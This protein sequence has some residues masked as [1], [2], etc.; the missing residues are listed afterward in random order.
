MTTFNITTEV[1]Y[2]SLTPKQ[3]NDS[4]NVNGGRLV[5]DCDTR[6]GPNTTAATG[7][8]GGFTASASLGGDL[9]V[10]GT[11]VRLIPFDS[12]SSTIPA[13]GT[14]ITCSTGTAE[15][16]CVM[17]EKHGG[18]MYASG[19]AMPTTGW[20]KVRNV[21]GTFGAEA[22]SGISCSATGAD[23]VGW[24][25]LAGAQD[26][27][28]THSR[29]GT[30]VFNG[31][32]YY[33]GVTNGTAGQTIQL[34]Y[35]VAEGIMAYPGVEIE[36]APGSDVYLFHPNAA[37]KFTSTHCSTDS[38]SSFVGISNAGVLI[39]GKGFDNSLCGYLPVAGCKVR[40]PNIITQCAGITGLA[41]NVTPNE[42]LS[43]R[44]KSNYMSSGN[45]WLKNVTG[46]WYWSI[47]QAYNCYI[48][49]LHGCDQILI[50]E[51]ATKLDI[52]EVHSG[53]SNYAGAPLAVNPLLFQQ[54]YNGGT[55]GSISGLRAESISNSGY[56]GMFVNLYDK[57]TFKEIRIGH[58]GIPTAVN[59]SLYINTCTNIVIDTLRTFTKRFVASSCSNVIVKE[60]YYADACV[61]TTQVTQPCSGV[62]LFGST[63][64]ATI[65]NF[66]NWPGV[67]N[68]H[69]Y[70]GLIY[71]STAINVK[72]RFCGT[73]QNPYNTGTIN[74]SGH[75]Y[76]DGGNNTNIKIQRNWVT[77]VRTSLHSGTN[78][79]KNLT[80]VNNYSIDPSK[81]IGPQQLDSQ[82]YANRHN[83]GGN[84]TSY[85][86]VYGNAMWDAFT[87]DTTT[88]ASLILSEKTSYNQD[89]YAINSGNPVFTS[90]GALVMKNLGDSATWTWPW[91][92]KGWT[93][94]STHLSQGQNTLNF[95]YEY[96]LD[97]GSGFSGIFK[98][99]NSTNLQSETG[100]DPV[101]GFRLRI[102]ISCAIAAIT[103]RL[104]GFRIDGTTTLAL[105]NEAL[106]PLDQAILNISGVAS[107]STVA[108]FKASY[109]L[110]SAPEAVATD[111][112]ASTVTLKYDYDESQ[113]HYI[114]KIRKPGYD[115]IE[116][117]YVNMLKTDIPV[118]QQENKDGF[119]VVVYGRGDNSTKAFVTISAP[120]S[121]IDVGNYRCKAEDVYDLVV[122]WQASV[123]G[124]RYNEVLRFDG[125][126]IIMMN[127]WRFRRALS[128]YTS[129]GLDALPVVDGQANASPDD[130]TNG[131]VDFKARS[132]RTYYINQQP[133]YTLNDFA[134]AVWDYSQ[135]NGLSAQTN[136]LKTKIAAETAVAIAASI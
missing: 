126:D 30:S 87:G 63:T 73:P 4:F 109:V 37:N 83:A 93:G 110:G 36:T 49:D 42:N 5:I 50:Q 89:A 39:I 56:A 64:D 116:L 123:T 69:P 82:V 8:L 28:H 113:S 9:I 33:V 115:P 3:G 119:S 128:V 127:G 10:N 59:G 19:A 32:K 48:R 61:G 130:E 107:G 16:L 79:T 40:I 26:K 20:L 114:V 55:V 38:R 88:R 90:Q 135:I 6:Y 77:G 2:T 78:T 27:S 117:T 91:V 1:N 68:I 86:A 106:Y 131:S 58:T 53:L 12:A 96:D 94:L 13:Y 43:K 57:W 71:C 105:Q 76:V 122:D 132:V 104:D 70:L 24:M 25:F 136:L 80:F 133:V 18:I 124:I 97:K 52:D 22:L 112:T 35:V 85:I 65:L 51:I 54:C 31:L 62:E 98:V 29:L 103:N 66:K 100:F 101:N 15:L 44:Y 129:A 21:V 14:T 99:V 75:I 81:T 34:P 74:Q 134:A 7:V 120:D 84:P 102:R 95:L 92:I 23:E 45:I 46:S 108:V 121:R 60:H 47:I 72:F 118:S 111:T 11:S 41:Q 17:A 67:D 125:T